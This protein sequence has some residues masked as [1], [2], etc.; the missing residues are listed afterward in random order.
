[1]GGSGQFRVV[2]HRQLITRHARSVATVPVPADR[3]WPDTPGARPA[4][5]L[6][7]IGNS[8]GTVELWDP[9]AGEPIGEIGLSLARTGPILSMAAV[10]VSADPGWPD[11]PGAR[12][13]RSLLAIGNSKGTIQCWDRIAGVTIRQSPTGR[14]GAVRS[15]AAVPVPA[16]PS[17]PDSPGAHPARTLLASGSDDGTVRLWDPLAG[18]QIGPPAAHLP[19][20]RPV[21]AVPIPADP[22][23]PDSPDA[24]PARTLIASCTITGAV[25]LWDP[26]A[27]GPI[28]LSLDR[29]DPIVSMVAVPVPADPGWPDT[30]GARPARTLL[31]T[32]SSDGRMQL[33]EVRLRDPIVAEQIAPPLTGHT[34]TVRSMV[35]VPVPADPSW[36]D[37][38]GAHPA[39]TLLASGSDDGTVR[40]WD[41]LAGEQIGPPAAHLPGAVAVAAVPVPADPGWPE[42][43]GTHPAR[44][45]LASAGGEGTVR[46]WELVWEVPVPRVPGYVSD[47]MSGRPRDLLDRHR[48]AAAIADLLTSRTAQPPLAVGVFGQWGEGK[49]Q[50]LDLIAAAV[51]DRAATAG[52]DDPIA[53]G[54]IRQVRFN[55][56]HYAEADL[57]ASLVAEIFTQL[58]HGP[59]A[60]AQADDPGGEAR[61]R[62]RLAAELIDAR[63]LRA[64][65]EGARARLAALEKVRTGR[66]PGLAAARAVLQHVRTWGWLRPFLAAIAVG[67]AL[68]ALTRLG[69]VDAATGWLRALPGVA[70]L[71]AA[72]ASLRRAWRESGPAREQARDLWKRTVAQ[73][74]HLDTA[75]AVARAEVTTLQRQL[76]DL[77]AA[78]QLAGLVADRATAGTYRER[79]GLMTQIRHDFD[80][81]AE[82]L[83]AAAAERR[84]RPPEDDSPS[85]GTPP[86]GA[87]TD[88]TGVAAESRRSEGGEDLVGDELPEID[89]IVLYIDDLDRCP[90]A[91][92]VEVLEA[93][94]LLLAGRLFVVVV[95]VDPR[96][97][98]GSIAAHYAELFQ[99]EHLPTAETW[100][101]G[102]AQYLE[103]IFQIVL[104]LPPLEQGG[105]RRLVDSLVGVRQD[106]LADLTET[107]PTTP[108]L[109]EA[110]EDGAE[111]RRRARAEPGSAAASPTPSPAGGGPAVSP[112]TPPPP[113]GTSGDHPGRTTWAAGDAR[114]PVTGLA[115]GVRSVERV[116]PLALTADELR[117]M[118]LL[119]PPLITS[120]RAVKRLTNSYG[121]L[122]AI[123]SRNP[124]GTRPELAVVDDSL[125]G[126]PGPAGDLTGGAPTSAPYRAGMVLLAVVVGYPDLG[127]RFFTALHGCARTTPGLAWQDWLDTQRPA[128]AT[129]G[130]HHGW[131]PDQREGERMNQLVD[132]LHQ[133][134]RAADAAG[135][136][137]P[138]RLQTWGDWVIPVGRLS[139][140]TGPAVTRLLTS[141]AYAPDEGHQP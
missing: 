140:P 16:D 28:G 91:R 84:A 54:A 3:G 43:P 82:L 56:W 23:W 98:Q 53:H 118:A 112:I 29:T 141:A 7:A 47:T 104:T 2:P 58:A 96:W 51:T 127:P 72:A 123:R 60:P 65:L 110:G 66:P 4:R 69:W 139:F 115:M 117:L 5:N 113:S 121:V 10:P 74:D 39:R 70:F 42:T 1:M 14:I 25:L 124:D 15:M 59:S 100:T 32:G 64:E 133:I 17:W 57:W 18:E 80:A 34:D 79:L 68:Y 33:W 46:L 19:G 93:V 41:P 125:D 102:P 136:P 131:P 116:D 114:D 50:F 128:P 45:L 8:G 11:T 62:S 83:L 37:S 55:A 20:A 40:L 87:A 88:A 97:L 48:D 75:I 94:H 31:A 35:A 90:P 107:A 85:G 63:G 105:Y 22:G 134:R 111:A 119:G 44:T 81:M 137:L 38:P 36:P 24:R 103:K 132:A 126:E 67:L 27:G 12:P 52:R 76:Q 26:V 130:T 78:G 99:G 49:S 6:V 61:R 109:P 122:T 89:R 9:V 73:R 30:P 92:V 135:L 21:A 138:R 108:G 120:P 13:A 71:T 95:A 101:D 77:T 106:Q 86:N 129:V